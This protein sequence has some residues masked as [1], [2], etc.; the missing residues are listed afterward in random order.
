MKF[1]Y[2]NQSL[3]HIQKEFENDE[4][5]QL[6]TDSINY[7]K[8]WSG[9]HEFNIIF[10]SRIN[11]NGKQVLAIIV[12]NKN[13]LYFNYFDNNNNIFGGYINNT[14][15]P[16]KYVND[17]NAFVCSFVRNGLS[18]NKQ[19]KIIKGKEEYAFYL[20]SNSDVLYH[21]GACFGSIERDIS[22]NKIGDRKSYCDLGR[23]SYNG[24]Q[25]PLR[26]NNH[27]P[28]KLSIK[29]IVVIQMV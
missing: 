17:P 15:T 22:V 5:L 21:F 19:Y 16:S 3:N 12:N 2:Y 20:Y 6:L 1:N 23:Y 28:N 24:E 29:R 9:K 13:K 11:G 18:K 27:E 25:T 10:D 8:E 14:I 26:D 7:L 4:E